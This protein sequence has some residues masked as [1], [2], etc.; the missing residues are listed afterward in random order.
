LAREHPHRIVLGIGNADRGE[1]AAGRRVVRLLRE[2]QPD[3]VEIIEL[4]GEATT[5]LARLERASSA[6]IVDACHAGAPPGTV[7]RFDVGEAPLPHARFGLSTHGM[8]LAE[9]IELA[10]A[11]RQLPRRC[12]VYA[13]EGG[14]FDAGAGVSPPVAR[15][16]PIVA[17]RISAELQEPE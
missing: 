1:D 9:A 10:R 6:W 3:A 5:L 15:A 16:I 14:R 8:G 4:D 2:Q 13:L 12:I 7:H 11:L 17:A